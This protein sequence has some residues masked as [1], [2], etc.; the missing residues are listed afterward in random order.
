MVVQVPGITIDYK[1][2]G[3][4]DISLRAVIILSFDGTPKRKEEDVY[5]YL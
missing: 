4:N 2:I 3:T 1:I 5:E